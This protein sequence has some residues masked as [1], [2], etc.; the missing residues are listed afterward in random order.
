M[1]DLVFIWTT[2]T[3][4]TFHLTLNMYTTKVAHYMVKCLT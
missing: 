2:S 1:S 4:N 3:P